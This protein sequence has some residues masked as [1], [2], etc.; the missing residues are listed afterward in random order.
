MNLQVITKPLTRISGLMRPLARNEQDEIFRTGEH[1][2]IIL[3]HPSS[4]VSFFSAG[5]PDIVSES[6]TQHNGHNP[7]EC[8]KR[9]TL[10]LRSQ[11]VSIMNVLKT[12]TGHLKLPRLNVNRS[13]YFSSISPQLPP[14]ISLSPALQTYSSD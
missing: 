6:V 10:T 14:P 9:H 12:N 1:R 4:R 11:S 2:V 5:C 8:I 7:Y 3:T 13:F